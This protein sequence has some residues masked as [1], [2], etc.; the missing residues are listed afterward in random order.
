LMNF[1]SYELECD[2]EQI[3]E[4]ILVLEEAI[5]DFQELKSRAEHFDSAKKYP[6]V[7]KEGMPMALKADHRRPQALSWEVCFLTRRPDFLC[8]IFHFHVL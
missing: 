7:P 6:S 3:N 1:T 5:S 8:F 4:S 2:M